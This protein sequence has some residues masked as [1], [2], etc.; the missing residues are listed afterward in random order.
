MSTPIAW[1]CVMVPVERRGQVATCSVWPGVRRAGLPRLSP[2]L[3]P[4]QRRRRRRLD[5]I[6]LNSAADKRGTSG[7]RGS[8]CDEVHEENRWPLRPEAKYWPGLPASQHACPATDRPWMFAGVHRWRWRL[9]LT[10]SLSRRS[11]LLAWHAEP[12][13]QDSGPYGGD[14][15]TLGVA[16]RHGWDVAI[17]EINES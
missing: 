17:R 16:V 11:P 6:R 8:H 7:E 13:P 10:W 9:S 2:A 15:G 3:T 14:V 12:G 1:C 5:Q 4:G